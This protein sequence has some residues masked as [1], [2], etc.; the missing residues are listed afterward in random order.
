VGIVD[1]TAIHRFYWKYPLFF[2]FERFIFTFTLLW[3][4]ISINLSLLSLVSRNK[5]IPYH[6]QLREK[7][8]T[9]DYADLLNLLYTNRFEQEYAEDLANAP[10]TFTELFAEYCDQWSSRQGAYIDQDMQKTLRVSQDDDEF[11]V[12]YDNSTVE[13]VFKYGDYGQSVDSYDTETGD[14]DTDRL[15]PNESAEIPLYM[16]LHIPESDSEN[17]IVVME[18]SNNVGMKLRFQGALRSQLIDGISN[19][20]S[21]MKD[22]SIYQTIR[23]ADRV[24]RFHVQTTESPDTL[25]GEFSSVFSPST[26]AKKMTYSPTE[27][28]EIRLDVNELENWIEGSDNPFRNVGGNTYTEFKLTVESA[29]SKTTID[30]FEQGVNLSRILDDVDMEGGHPVPSYMGQEARQF[31]N[32]E[33]LPSGADSIPTSSLL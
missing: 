4:A 17:A 8:Q 1:T 10:Q 11:A 24:A 3:L 7:N 30:F 15:E 23:N 12:D 31:V 18:E 25:G 14:A 28:G 32:Q 33:L 26:T 22:E 9:A 13:A 20:I 6:L 5:L 21:T 29:G 2:R 16:L 27:D 19:E